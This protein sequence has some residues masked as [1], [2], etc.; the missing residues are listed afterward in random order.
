MEIRKVV[1]TEN[2]VKMTV[3]LW[4]EPDGREAVVY[5][6]GYPSGNVQTILYRKESGG[7][8]FTKDKSA[9]LF[10]GRFFIDIVSA[11]SEAG[12]RQYGGDIPA[13][14]K[15]CRECGQQPVF[16][17]QPD[18][19]YEGLCFS[20]KSMEE[21]VILDGRSDLGR[22]EQQVADELTDGE[23]RDETCNS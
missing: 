4:K 22:Y 15:V 12:R 23:E 5:A 19:L 18:R 1:K 8:G 14:R 9:S 10:L 13:T 6:K 11:V 21:G 20:C 2:M 7:G 16:M 3:S 17:G